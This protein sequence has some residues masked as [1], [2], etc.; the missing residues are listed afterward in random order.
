MYFGGFTGYRLLLADF[1]LCVIMITWKGVRSQMR[2]SY[3]ISKPDK[4]KK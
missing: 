1:R 3:Q 2:N 4:G